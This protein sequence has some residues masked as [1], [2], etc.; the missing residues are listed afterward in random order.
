MNFTVFTGLH[1]G[2]ITID[3]VS[4][5]DAALK[6]ATRLTSHG[7]IQHGKAITFL[8]LPTEDALW[9]DDI[10]HST[11]VTV[12]PLGRTLGSIRALDHWTQVA[13]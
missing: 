1:A 6:V 7:H 9:G 5:Q 11:R 3:A 10:S 13:V 2:T 12:T 8:V 4:E